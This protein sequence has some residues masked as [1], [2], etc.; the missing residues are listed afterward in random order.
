[1]RSPLWFAVA[2]IVAIGGFVC[3]GFYMAP[4][5]AHMIPD[6]E[7]VVLPGSKSLTLD[8]AGAYTLY[9]ENKS[10][11]D[12]TYYVSD[13]PAGVQISLTAETTGE[14]VKLGDPRNGWSYSMNSRSGKALAGFV[15]DQPGRYRLSATLSSGRV[16]AP[17]V[18]AVGYGSMKDSFAR[19]SQALGG[20]FVF[21]FGGIAI[22]GT[23]AGVTLWQRMKA[24]P[25]R[26]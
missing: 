11:A 5:L 15:I 23:I 12:G 25:A 18:L 7:R 2:G 3:G 10:F 21:S 17:F 13:L 20:F 8:R 14:Q 19:I 9:F 24:K 1:M 22:G 26:T 16:A 4:R 6:L